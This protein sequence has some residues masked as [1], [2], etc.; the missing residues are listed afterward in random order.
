MGI[1]MIDQS[2]KNKLKTLIGK[3]IS[4]K[5]EKNDNS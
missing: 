2:L 1:Y 5:R 3:V 4:D